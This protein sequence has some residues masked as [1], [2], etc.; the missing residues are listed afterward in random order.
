MP[1]VFFNDRVQ[2]EAESRSISLEVIQYCLDNP[3]QV[4][5]YREFEVHCIHLDD[6]QTLKVTLR[7]GYIV[8]AYIV[9]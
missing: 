7:G 6:G 4:Y 1:A 8:R 2:D 3:A 9:R 5:A